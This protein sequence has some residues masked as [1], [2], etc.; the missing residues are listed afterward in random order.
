MSG[1]ASLDAQPGMHTELQQNAVGLTGVI[2]QGVGTIAPAFGI[3][4]GFQFTVGLAGVAAPAAYFIAALLLLTAAITVTQLAKAFPSAG[5]WYTWISR[6]LHPRAGFIAAWMMLIWMPLSP[7]ISFAYVG[8]AVIEPIM[9]S[10]YGLDVPWWT[11]P[12]VGIAIVA[13]L[14]HRGISLSSRWLVAFGFLEMGIMVAL[15]LFAFASPGDGGVNVEPLNPFNAP[16]GNS[17]WLAIIFSV[18]VF[19]GW[20]NVAPLAEESRNPRRNVPAALIISV[21]IVTLFFVVTAWGYIVGLGTNQVAGIPA[22]TDNPTF[23]LAERLWGNAWWLVLIA[24]LNSTLAVAVAMFNGATRTFYA[25]SRSGV[26]PQALS[27]V[28]PIRRVPDNALLLEL[29]VCVGVFIVTAAFGGANTLFNWGLIITFGLIVAYVLANLGVI[30]Y[31]W[32]EARNEFNVVLHLILPIVSSVVALLVAYNS[33]VP[34]PAPPVDNAPYIFVAY[35]A[36]G[37]VMLGIMRLRGQERWLEKATMAVAEPEAV[38]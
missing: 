34:M 16:S 2:M 22:L 4:A 9:K 14:V 10:Q 37:L 33:V 28:D 30:R 27:K 26:L 1:S 21:S 12:I 25:M 5:G 23:V 35:A 18:F 3:V 17:L 29:V 11:I 15:A 38:A 20:E 6:S 24:L 13:F 31:Y 32:V 8:Q 19:S 36:L 7:V